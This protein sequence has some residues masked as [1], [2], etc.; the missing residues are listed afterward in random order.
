MKDETKKKKGDEVDRNEHKENNELQQ[1]HEKIRD[2]ENQV[3]RVLA[4]YH[5]AQKRQM[6][7]RA[8]WIKSANKDLLL[9]LLPVVDTL[10]LASTHSKDQTLQVTLQQFLDVLQQIGVQRIKTVGKA[11]DPVTM[12][13]VDTAE[14]EDGKVL[15]TIS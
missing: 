13:C 7:E 11:F 9:R 4:D 8:E 5:N 2:L 14:G 6:Q 15:E 12:E 10:L 1:A 3:K